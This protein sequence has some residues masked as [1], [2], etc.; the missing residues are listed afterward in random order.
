MKGFSGWY[1]KST[2]YEDYTN[3]IPKMVK[4]MS[5]ILLYKITQMVFLVYVWYSFG[6]RQGLVYH[7]Y[8]I[9]IGIGGGIACEMVLLNGGKP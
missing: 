2:N 5:L 9:P 3:G 1:G 8:Q 6:I 4:I 7:Q